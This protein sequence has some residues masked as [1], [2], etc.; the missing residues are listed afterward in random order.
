LS[1]V[2]KKWA[3][4]YKI[5]L[6]SDSRLDGKSKKDLKLILK[7]HLEKFLEM[8]YPNIEMELLQLS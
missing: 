7:E 6:S 8:D 2:P 4:I 5:K 3:S 1:Q